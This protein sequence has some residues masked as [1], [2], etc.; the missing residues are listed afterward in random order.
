MNIRIQTWQRRVSREVKA[1]SRP[2]ASL[3]Q[4]LGDGWPDRV[5]PEDGAGR[6]QPRPTRRHLNDARYLQGWAQLDAS[7]PAGGNHPGRAG[8]VRVRRFGLVAWHLLGLG[9]AGWV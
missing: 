9:G 4:G 6:S 1:R 7:L 5:G 3:A 2:D 8:L